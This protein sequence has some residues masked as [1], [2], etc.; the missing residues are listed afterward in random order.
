MLA[1]CDQQHLAVSGTQSINNG[2]KLHHFRSRSTNR[3]QGRL[4]RHIIGTSSFDC[5]EDNSDADPRTAYQRE[6]MAANAF[7]RRN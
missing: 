4:A 3:H 7:G 1:C 5:L 2:E 6:T